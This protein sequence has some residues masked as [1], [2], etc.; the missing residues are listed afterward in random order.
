M[1]LLMQ[2][3][4]LFSLVGSLRDYKRHRK[5]GPTVLAIAS[6]AAIIYGINANLDTYFIFPGIVG[7]LIV[8]TWSSIEIKRTASPDDEHSSE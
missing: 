2:A 6:A 5:M 7:M 8:S 4:V 1:F 3:I